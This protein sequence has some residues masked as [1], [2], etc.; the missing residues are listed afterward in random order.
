MR[1]ILTGQ[2]IQTAEAGLIDTHG[3]SFSELCDEVD[4]TSLDSALDLIIFASRSEVDIHCG[5]NSS[6]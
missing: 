3:L 5:F 6:I 4:E 2:D 1:G